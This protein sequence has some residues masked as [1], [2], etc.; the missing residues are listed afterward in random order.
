[1]PVL[2]AARNGLNA[3]G[4][5]VTAFTKENVGDKKFET[6]GHVGLVKN[7]D[8][9]TAILVALGNNSESQLS[10]MR[11]SA[12]SEIQSQ[13]LYYFGITGTSI[14]SV[15]DSAGLTTNPLS[16]PPDEGLPGT[17]S[18][19]TG[20][21]S[22]DIIVP[23]DQT[24]T[25]LF[26]T[27]VDPFSIEIT[28]ETDIPDLAVRYQ[29]LVLPQG[30]LARIR[31]TPHGIEDLMYDVNN[32]GVFETTVN[33]NISVTGTAAQDAQPP[34]VSITAVPQ[35]TGSLISISSSDDGAGVQAT[36]Y[37]LNGQ[38]FQL[39]SGQ[40]T[41]NKFQAPV[42]YAF[43]DDKVGNRSSIVSRELVAFGIPV[44]I[45]QTDSTRAVALDSLLRTT[46]PFRGT[47]EYLW[48]TDKR[49]RIILF[50]MNFTLTAEE[51]VSAVTATAEDINNRIYPLTVEY[52]GQTPNSEWM[53]TIVVRLN[54]ELGDA[55]DV[56]VRITYHGISSN[57]VRIGIGHIG[58]GPPDP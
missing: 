31:L 32:D 15:S 29:D 2:S 47:Y 6:L 10:L 30:V 50:A 38:D 26:R 13:E 48:G 33:P 49:T 55:G 19:I 14:L 16:D 52:I 34:S 24:Y 41:I 25:V 51:N 20:K 3:S 28:R 22:A 45:T 58:G 21:K 40:F 39:Y 57:P 18:N 4:S 23:L 8:V 12:A 56:L 54:D 44:L 42:V 35:G 5:V 46:E 36:Y 9:R 7:N 1:M 53:K 17:V 11:S 43:S 27:D 37:S